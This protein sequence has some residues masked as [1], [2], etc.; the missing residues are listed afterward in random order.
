[1]LSID[2]LAI[3]YFRENSL[4]GP[5]KLTSSFLSPFF[6][7]E[8]PYLTP[9]LSFFPKLTLLLPP[10]GTA[11]NSHANLS[12]LFRNRPKCPCSILPPPLDSS[13]L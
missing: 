9:Q 2:E 3:I 11:M 12:D 10:L 13:N 4:F 6:F 8:L 1:M 7:P 5:T